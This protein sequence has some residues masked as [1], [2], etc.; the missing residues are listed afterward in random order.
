MGRELLVNVRNGQTLE[1]E[2]PSSPAASAVVDSAIALREELR[3][4]AR[5][6]LLQV[7]RTPDNPLASVVRDLL[8]LLD[9]EA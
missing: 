2:G 1:R 8:T 3:E 5:L 7:A 9:V 4:G 6:R